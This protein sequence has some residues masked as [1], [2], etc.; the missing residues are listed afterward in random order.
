ME[1]YKMSSK[2]INKKNKNSIKMEEKI[3]NKREKTFEKIVESRHRRSTGYPRM[4][5][6][7]F[8]LFGSFA[9]TKYHPL[10]SSDGL[11]EAMKIKEILM[12][13][14]YYRGEKWDFWYSFE[15]ELPYDCRSV[16]VKLFEYLLDN[17]EDYEFFTDYIIGEYLDLLKN[18]CANLSLYWY[19]TDIAEEAFEKLLERIVSNDMNEELEELLTENEIEICSF[20]N[21]LYFKSELIQEIFESEAISDKVIDLIY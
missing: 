15:K 7:D 3:M 12:S 18:D 17:G 13:D 2:S 5:R 16:I 6:E 11:K 8:K 4:S 1:A 9:A 14:R 10:S 19:I 20:I 21:K